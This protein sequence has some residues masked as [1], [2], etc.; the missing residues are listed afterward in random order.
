M[1]ALASLSRSGFKA[2]VPENGAF[3]IYIE[4]EPYVRELVEAYLA[5]SFKTVLDILNKYSV[6]VLPLALFMDLH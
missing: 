1:C 6:S 5:S 4:Q 3:G 2:Q